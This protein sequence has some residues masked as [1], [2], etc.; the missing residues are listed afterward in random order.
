MLNIQNHFTPGIVNSYNDVR[1]LHLLQD[2]T[3]RLYGCFSD[4]KYFL[5]LAL[6]F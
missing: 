6:A 1:W 3:Q 4:K 2:D 5:F